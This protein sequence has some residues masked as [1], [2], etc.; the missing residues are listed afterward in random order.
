MSFWHRCLVDL[1]P[2]L[3]LAVDQL[4]NLRVVQLEKHARNLAR[5]VLRLRLGSG[6]FGAVEPTAISTSRVVSVYKGSGGLRPLRPRGSPPAAAGPWSRELRVA[7][8]WG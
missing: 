8:R 5:I 1:G 7:Q 2:Q 6:G 3:G 4:D